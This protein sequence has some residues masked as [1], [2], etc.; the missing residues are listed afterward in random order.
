MPTSVTR[1]AFL[2]TALGAGALVVPLAQGVGAATNTLYG[3]RAD[4]GAG[5]PSCVPNR[6]RS[7]CG[8]CYACVNHAH[9]K[10]FATAAAA[11]TGRA[12]NH[13][14]CKV[15]TL[16]AVDD[17][18]YEQ[19]F[20]AGT[21]ADR[22]TP[23]INKLLSRRRSALAGPLLP[24]RGASLPRTGGSLAPLTLGGAGAV[25]LGGVLWRA[26]RMANSPVPE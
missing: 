14:K 9:N 7:D 3:L 23:G 24:A 20:K 21:S 4:W 10:V 12:H 5:D 2:G 17:A 8:G 1:R 16:F 18:I 19:L 13:C 26:G 11:N 15:V 6:G 22:R 25:I